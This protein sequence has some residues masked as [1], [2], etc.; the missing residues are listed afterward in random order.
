MRVSSNAERSCCRRPKKKKKK[1]KKKNQ[2]AAV[3]DWMLGAPK[4]C[5][6]PPPRPRVP[7]H[8]IN[9]RRCRWHYYHIPLF[10]H[11][12]HMMRE[13]AEGAPS[14]L[15]K[16]FDTRKMVEICFFLCWN[17]NYTQQLHYCCWRQHPK[18][19][20]RSYCVYYLCNG[21]KP[22]AVCVP[23]AQRVYNRAAE[24][25]AVPSSHMSSHL[26]QSLQMAA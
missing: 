14:I 7:Q 5:L 20:L 24:R 21:A 9:L 4:H 22:C 8:L 1:K 13:T 15:E 25:L 3:S 17:W 23:R 19:C 2:C 18:W 10:L 26:Q 12:L 6:L 11:F 16:K